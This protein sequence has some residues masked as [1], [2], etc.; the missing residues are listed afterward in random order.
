SPHYVDAQAAWHIVFQSWILHVDGKI[1][2]IDPCIGNGRS[3]THPFAQMFHMLDTP[4]IERFE[5]TG[6]RPEDV[7]I[8]FCTHLH[9]DHC[10][11]NTR[12]R[13]DR[14]VPTFPNARYIMVRRE[15]DHWN[16]KSKKEHLGGDVFAGLFENSV[17]PVVDAG[18]AELVEDRHRL[19][20]SLMIEPSYGH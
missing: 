3:Y 4:Y 18:L 15:F 8:V 6:I 5:A 13:G 14:F 12:L 9:V 11:W 19:S 1:V 20:P 16:P 10:G 2:V 7:D 17:Q